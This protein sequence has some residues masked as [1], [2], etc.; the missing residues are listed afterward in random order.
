MLSVNQ[1]LASHGVNI[2]F[3]RALSHGDL[4]VWEALRTDLEFCNLSEHQD[5][6]SWALEPSGQFLVNSM[7]KLLLQGPA[8]PCAKLIWKA[9]LP[10]KIKIF[11]W[12]LAIDRLPSSEQINHRHGP[13][14]SFCVMCG[15]VE[16]TDHI[17][18]KCG[19]A[20]FMWSGIR[21]ILNVTWNPSFFAQF[22]QIIS[23]LSHGHEKAVWILFAAQSMALWQIRNKIAME[24]SFPNQPADCVLK[25]LVFLQ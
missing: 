21:T 25:T 17:F 23:S 6:V 3:R 10:L 7:Y 2:V 15:H 12:Q 4:V 24:N 8:W 9:N 1:A 20:I 16:S 18:F 14:D 11:T 13:T 5:R 19:F 22:F